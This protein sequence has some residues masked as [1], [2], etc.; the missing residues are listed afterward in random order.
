MSQQNYYFQHSNLPEIGNSEEQ[1]FPILSSVS[2][3][4]LGL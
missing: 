2:L 3:S 1:R 4:Y